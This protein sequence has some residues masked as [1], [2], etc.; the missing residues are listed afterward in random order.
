L[1]RAPPCP[2]SPDSCQERVGYGLAVPFTASCCSKTRKRNTLEKRCN[3]EVAGR[4]RGGWDKGARLDWR[5]FGWLA[6]SKRQRR[7]RRDSQPKCRQDRESAP[8]RVKEGTQT[9]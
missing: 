7:A 8:M 9:R 5:L 1:H 2:N 6:R 4:W 3:S